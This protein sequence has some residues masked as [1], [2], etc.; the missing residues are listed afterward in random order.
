MTELC[1]D[2]SIRETVKNIETFHTTGNNDFFIT[3]V[4]NPQKAPSG[5][6]ELM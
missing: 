1:N 4:C 3:T 5:N 6:A 2:Y